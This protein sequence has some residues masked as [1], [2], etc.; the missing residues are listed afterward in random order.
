M[1]EKIINWLKQPYIVKS[2]YFIGCMIASFGL[3]ILTHAHA[4]NQQDLP[5]ISIPKQPIPIAYRYK[6]PQ[7]G[8]FYDQLPAVSSTG[9]VSENTEM[10]SVQATV[11]QSMSSQFVGSKTGTKYYP[12]GCSGINRI[13]EENRVYFTTEQEAMD[14]GYE[15]TSTCK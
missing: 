15:R 12:V 5:T 2:I 6:N 14:K 13:K 10:E 4:I 11:P 8:N 1:E 3:G 9:I 7:I